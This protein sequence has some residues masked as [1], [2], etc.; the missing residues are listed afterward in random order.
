MLI[1]QFFQLAD[2]GEK[3]HH[4]ISTRPLPT[5]GGLKLMGQYVPSVGGIKPRL[6]RLRVKYRN[7][8]GDTDLL[9]FDVSSTGESKRQ[10]S[11]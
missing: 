7:L 5:N 3:W 10:V 11:S 8:K 9:C 2:N 4:V 6:P 1:V